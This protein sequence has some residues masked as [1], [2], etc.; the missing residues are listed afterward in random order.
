MKPITILGMT[1]TDADNPKLSFETCAKLALDF[2]QASEMTDA[3]LAAEW[4][5]TLTP[6][7]DQVDRTHENATRAMN[8]A[9]IQFGKLSTATTTDWA[10]AHHRWLLAVDKAKDALEQWRAAAKAAEKVTTPGDDVL[11][12]Y[13]TEVPSIQRITTRLRCLQWRDLHDSG[14][15]FL[16]EAAHRCALTAATLRHLTSITSA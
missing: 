12:L 11:A 10:A 9:N 14:A 2:A 16:D 4:H 8:N 5:N 1:G 13:R 6:L 3:H 7:L 15:K